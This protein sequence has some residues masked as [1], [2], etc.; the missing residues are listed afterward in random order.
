MRLLRAINAHKALTAS[1]RGCLL[2]EE[3]L[4]ECQRR[5]LQDL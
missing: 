1:K 2:L 3:S 5:K 4:K